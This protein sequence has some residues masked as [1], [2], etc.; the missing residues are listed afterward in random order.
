VPYFDTSKPDPTLA[1]TPKSDLLIEFSKQD[2]TGNFGAAY[3]RSTD[4]GISWAPFQFFDQPISNT[5]AF[6]TAFLNVG[7]TIYAASYGPSTASSGFSPFLW[8][9]NDD[10]L[11]WTK[12]SGLRKPGEP[13]LNETAIIQ[14]SPSQLLSISR[15]DDGLEPYGRRSDDMGLTWGPLI[16]YTSQIGVLHLPQFVR[17]GP[18]LVLLGR[19]TLGIPGVQPPNTVGYPRQLAAFVSYDNGQNFQ[20]GTVLDTY[21]G[22]Q[23]DGGYCWPIRLS[24]GTLF[25]VYYADSNNLARPDIKSVRLSVVEPRHPAAMHFTLSPSLRQPRPVI[26][27]A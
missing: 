2:P 25:V 22:R 6:S 27:W 19:E 13:G 14:T 16:S 10:G 7:T 23:I 3:S 24:D 17:A 20:Y 9:S 8:F 12:L 5:S 26:S 4:N 18:A 1:L 21:T 15:A 11:S